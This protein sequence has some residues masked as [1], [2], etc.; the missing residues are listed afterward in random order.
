MIECFWILL[1]I[2]HLYIGS[3]SGIGKMWERERIK[4]EI[5]DYVKWKGI[6]VYFWYLQL[7]WIARCETYQT[8]PK[9]QLH[10]PRFAQ[11]HSIRNGTRGK[12]KGNFYIGRNVVNVN[13]DWR[14]SWVNQMLY[15]CFETPTPFQPHTNTVVVCVWISVYIEEK[16]NAEWYVFVYISTGK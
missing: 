16:G 15:F 6:I 12:G 14:F 3:N 2:Q 4:C 8:K 1:S 13:L 7:N 9:K 10:R 5:F 11:N